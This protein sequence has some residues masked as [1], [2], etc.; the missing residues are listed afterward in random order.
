[1][2]IVIDVLTET[3]SHHFSIAHIR[4]QSPYTG[5]GVV[6]IDPLHFL[7]GCRKRRLNQ[8]LSVWSLSIRFL[9]MLLFIRAP[10]CVWLIYVGMYVFYLWLLWLSF[11]P[12]DWLERL[13][14]SLIVARGTISTK[15]RPK[16]VYDFL[17]SVYCFIVWLRICF[18]PCFTFIGLLWHDIAWKCQ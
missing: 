3:R 17:G 2:I 15:P 18:V 8:V 14:G 13:W 10:F 12:S 5:S 7:A 4:R 16:S 11:L 1:M 9:S 6:R